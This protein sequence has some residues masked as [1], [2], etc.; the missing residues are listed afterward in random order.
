MSFDRVVG[1]AGQRY[2]EGKAERLGRAFFS[3]I[4]VKQ[5]RM[6]FARRNM[7]L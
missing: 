6:L 3:A 1:A 4:S 2:R 5:F 7:Y